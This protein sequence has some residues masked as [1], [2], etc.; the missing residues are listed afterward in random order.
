MAIPS[1]LGHTDLFLVITI[2]EAPWKR[3]GIPMGVSWKSHGGVHGTPMELP[4]GR[5]WKHNG[6]ELQM[7]TGYT[8]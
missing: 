5:S 1:L 2:D 6:S 3:H 8:K 4:W 7:H